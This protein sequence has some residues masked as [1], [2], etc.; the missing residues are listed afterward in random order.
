M[1]V[2]THPFVVVDQGGENHIDP[3]VPPQLLEAGLDRGPQRFLIGRS[4]DTRPQAAQ[5]LKGAD[6]DSGRR[7]FSH[8]V[9]HVPAFGP[10]PVGQKSS[11]ENAKVHGHPNAGTPAHHV[12]RH[13]RSARLSHNEGA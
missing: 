5:V 2:V 11:P 12:S 10:R 4:E 8:V 9:T 3:R 6:A 13:E 1:P 7:F